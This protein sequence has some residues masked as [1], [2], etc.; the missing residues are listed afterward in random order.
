M[1]YDSM[2]FR[3]TVFVVFDKKNF[4]CILSKNGMKTLIA[5]VPEMTKII[6]AAMDFSPTDLLKIHNMYECAVIHNFY[7]G[8]FKT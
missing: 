7:N 1:H 2:A 5:K 3:Y 6:G 8:F 4:C